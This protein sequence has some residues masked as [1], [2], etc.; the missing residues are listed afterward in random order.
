VAVGQEG[1]QGG[2]VVPRLALPPLGHLGQFPQGQAAGVAA[3]DAGESPDDGPGVS[4]A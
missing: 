4:S 1:E 2:G 3:D